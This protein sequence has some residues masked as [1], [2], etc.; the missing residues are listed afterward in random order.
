MIPTI[1]TIAPEPVDPLDMLPNRVNPAL[2]GADGDSDLFPMD[3]EWL[4]LLHDK[5]QLSR[6]TPEWVQALLAHKASQG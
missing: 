4:V 5:G 2:S 1:A 6:A 3:A